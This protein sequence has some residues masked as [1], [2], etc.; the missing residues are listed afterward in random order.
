MERCV[1]CGYSYDALGRPEIAPELRVRALAYGQ[2]LG[3]VEPGRLRA[4][5]RAGVWSA[6]EYS[7]HVRDVLEVQRDRVLLASAENEPAFV[8]MRRDERVTENRYNDQNPALVLEQM[9]A[10]A[11]ALADTL[12][13]LDDDGWSRT[14][15][16]NWPTTAVRTVE[17]IGRHTVHEQVHHQCD[18][19]DLLRGSES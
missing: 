5:P 19:E 3:A 2:L 14:G 6:L 18:I 10:A 7:C 9:A 12:E 16:Y 13:A 11:D 15:I 1:E 8:P 4:Y 17:W